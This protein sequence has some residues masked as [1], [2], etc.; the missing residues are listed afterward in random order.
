MLG[1]SWR[2]PKFSNKITG[3]ATAVVS[4]GPMPFLTPNQHRQ[5]TT[6]YQVQEI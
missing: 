4:T 3:T 5:S 2:S 1:V 6:D